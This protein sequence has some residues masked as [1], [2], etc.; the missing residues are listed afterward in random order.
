M[1]DKTING[2]VTWLRNWFYTQ[3]EVDLLVSES[4]ITY[5]D[6]FNTLDCVNNNFDDLSNGN[7]TQL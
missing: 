6:L 3:D 2:I 4:G 1:V 5:T 7:Y